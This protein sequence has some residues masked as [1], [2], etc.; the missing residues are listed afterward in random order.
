MDSNVLKKLNRRELLEMLYEQSRKMDEQ[1]ILIDTLTEQ[2]ENKEIIKENAGSIADA[3]MQLSDI[4]NVAQDTANVYIDSVIRSKAFQVQGVPDME[5]FKR[6]LRVSILYADK[7]KGQMKDLNDEFT[8][9][10]MVLRVLEDS[11]K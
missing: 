3:A 2:V 5:L 9:F 11:L 7:L 10:A 8:K 6:A 1:Q 4:F